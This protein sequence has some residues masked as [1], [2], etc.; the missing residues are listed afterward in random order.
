MKKIIIY[1]LI[2]LVGI[3][4]AKVKNTNKKSARALGVEQTPPANYNSRYETNIYYRD[5]EGDVSDWIPDAGWMHSD[6][7][8][9]SPD[10]SF[11]S[12]N[13]ET[14]DAE[15]SALDSARAFWNMLSPDIQIPEIADNDDIYFKFDLR[16]DMPDSD[17]DADI[18]GY[19]DD[20]YGVSVRQIDAVWH[21]SDFNSNNGNSY[22]A[23]DEEVGGYLNSWIQYLDTPPIDIPSTG[24]VMDTDMYWYIES[25]A[26]AAG[27]VPDYPEIDGWDQAVVLVSDDGGSTFS[28]L[29]SDNG[30]D[31]ECGYGGAWNG[32]GCLPGWAEQSAWH[33]ESFNL[34]AY[35]GQNI[36]IRFAFLSDPC[37]ATS[38]PECTGLTYPDT[39]FQVDNIVIRSGDSVLF[40]DNADEEQQMVASGFGSWNDVFYDYCDPD[41]GSRPG[42]LD[43]QTY[44]PGLAFN[45]NVMM[46]LSD[47]Q[48][49][50]VRFKFETRYDDDDYNPTPEPGT[51]LWVDNFGIYVNT[52]YGAPTGITADG[53][54]ASAMISWNSVDS[55]A[56]VT[57]N[58]FQDNAII[59][60]GVMDNSFMATGLM[61]NSDYSFAV[62]WV[63]PSGEESLRSGEVSVIPQAETVIEYA[64]DDGTS[65]D[66]INFG[67]QHSTAIK[68]SATG[69]VLRFNWYQMQSGGA[70]H[71]KVWE[72]VDG[73]P[74]GEVYSRIVNNGSVGWNTYNINSD[75]PTLVV[76]GDFWMGF[77]E[78]STTSPFGFDTSSENST[79]MYRTSPSDAWSLISDAG[80]IGNVMIHAVIDTDSNITCPPGDLN[81]DGSVNVQDI[82]GMV[83]SILG[84]ILLTDDQLCSAD[85]NGDGFVNVLDVTSVVNIILNGE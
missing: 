59:A 53:M 18:D 55:I 49:K 44:E 85:M 38:D 25:A 72:D 54:D 65:E 35:S 28:P 71:I 26:G 22:W 81:L 37:Y 39:G 61:N 62:S 74:G 66:G 13:N 56:G 12:P 67:S 41:I 70:F 14:T 4:S 11:N 1:A 63:H 16:C 29:Y 75:D 69:M 34:S 31:F 80:Y 83:N 46:D 21:A 79:T 47:F 9:S 5:F 15:G 24:A 52:M 2:P 60:T 20:Y 6:G 76:T 50:T 51:G 43:W 36:I 27:A 73:V 8:S 45:G 17:G 57:Y 77:S 68:F 30:Y 78:F 58:V 40:S 3:L 7:N 48:G 64:Y 19:L 42:S 82:L 23:G 10:Y 33:N 32:L 84:A